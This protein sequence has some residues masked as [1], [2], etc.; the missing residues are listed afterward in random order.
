MNDRDAINYIRD[1][2]RTNL[3]DP[4]KPYY[5]TASRTFVHTDNPR[6]DATFPR[7]IIH[8]R[9][10]S[11]NQ[12][13]EMGDNFMEWRSM[14]L[15]IE[16]WSR[17]GFKHH[18]GTA[19]AYTQDQEFTKYYSDYIWRILKAGGST[20]RTT[21]KIGGLKNMG[22]DEPEPSEDEQFYKLNLPVRIWYFST[23]S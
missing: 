23:S 20:I 22:E 19:S 21:Y 17:I 2:L 13:I 14:V 3:T 11:N 12:I 4:L 9:G 6:P 16:V 18:I 10:P 1:Y 8:K 5:S 7:V 15:D